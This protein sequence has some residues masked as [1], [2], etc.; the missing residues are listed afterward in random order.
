M[1]HYIFA[2][3][4]LMN[5]RS[6]A[7]TL[8]GERDVRRAIVHGYRRKMSVPFDG[9]AYLNLIQDANCA[10]GGILIPVSE[11]EFEL[12][13]SREEG[14]DRVD[15]TRALER[16]LDGVAYAF[17][18][19][20]SDSELKVPRSYIETCTAGMTDEEKKQWVEDTIMGEIE[21]DLDDPVYEF[22]A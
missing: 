13:S 15:V 1:Q 22:H 7:K 9:Y 2:Y 17:I 14:Y 20:D 4:S 3:G 11:A 5:P 21:E 18:A 6:L 12:F 8:P 10:V 16:A 19:P